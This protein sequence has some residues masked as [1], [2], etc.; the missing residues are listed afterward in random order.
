M[1]LPTIWRAWLQRDVDLTGKRKGLLSPLRIFVA[2]VALIFLAALFVRFSVGA[3]GYSG[4][5]RPPMFGDYEAQRHWMEISMHLPPHEW[6]R[7]TTNNDLQYWGLDYP[8][9]SAYL[10]WFFGKVAEKV[11]DEGVAFTALL[12]SRGYESPAT[13]LYMRAT[14]IACDVAFFLPSILFAVCLYNARDS[15]S[16]RAMMT[17]LLFLHPGTAHTAHCFALCWHVS[18][19][20]SLSLALS[21]E[22]GENN[23]GVSAATRVCRASHSSIYLSSIFVDTLGDHPPTPSLCVDR[24]RALPVQRGV[25]GADAVGDRKRA[26]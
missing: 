17:F 4:Q 11:L 7:N 15:S 26:R 22:P 1:L 14:V 5:G 3:N 23:S 25:P 8:P 10:A 24:P 20:L 21:L 12:S 2:G 19:T 9:L 6:Y 16:A 18:L 13:K